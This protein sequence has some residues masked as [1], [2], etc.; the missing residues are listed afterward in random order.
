MQT[1][2]DRL[3]MHRGTLVLLD[4]ATGRLR[5]ETA[6]GL[7]SEDIERNRFALGEGI[8]G[9][10]VAT[11]RARVIPRRASRPRL[12]ESHQPVAQLRRCERARS[13]SCACRSEIDG[14]TAGAVA[15]D[16]IYT[17]AERLAADQT[18]VEIITAFLAQAIQIN[19]MVM[20]QKGG[21]ARGDRAA[22]GPGPRPLQ[23]RQHHRRL[24]RRCTRCSTSSARSPTAGRRCCCSAR[25][26]RAR[27]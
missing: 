25:P 9:N 21:V 19:R 18:F 8:T 16:K 5:T 3:G 20:R 15:V 17:T 12:S 13:A 11:G 1:M 4:E 22:P 6:F 26:A 14:R 7:A 23:V 10:V 27:R 24:A 2:S